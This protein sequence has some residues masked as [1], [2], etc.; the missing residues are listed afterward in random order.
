MT[1]RPYSELRTNTR[2]ERPFSIIKL[3]L[4]MDRSQLHQRINHRVD[5]MMEEGLEEEARQLYPHKHL[6]SLNTVGYRELFQYFD[7]AIPLEKAV[8]LIKRNS[9]RYARKQLSWFRRDKEIS[10]FTPEN[11]DEVIKFVESKIKRAG[12]HV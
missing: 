10:W 3:G 9:R 7:G 2:K 1:G 11:P 5:I 4:D 12:T 8:E 6:N